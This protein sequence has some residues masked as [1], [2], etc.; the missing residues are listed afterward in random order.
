MVTQMS[1]FGCRPSSQHQLKLV[2]AKEHSLETKGV[3][4]EIRELKPKQ[5]KFIY[6]IEIELIPTKVAGNTKYQLYILNKSGQVQKW[7]VNKATNQVDINKD[8]PDQIKNL[9]ELSDPEI[10]R[11]FMEK[12][13][14]NQ[15]TQIR[16]NKDETLY[17]N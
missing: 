2:E 17:K 14:Q 5:D 15:Q 9:F 11:I 6:A 3:E 7:Q 1:C 13:Y 4:A 8:K 16:D 10:G 12:Y